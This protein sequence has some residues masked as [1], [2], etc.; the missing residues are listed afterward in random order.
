MKILAVEDSPSSRRLLQGIFLR[1]GVALPDI[2]LA[3]NATEAREIFSTWHPDVVF[4][5][6]E[7][8][9]TGAFPST[10]KPA[11][12]KSPRPMNGDELGRALLQEDPSVRLVVVTAYDPRTPAV[13]TLVAA[14]ATEVIVKPVLASRISEVLER[15][16]RTRGAG[17]A[18]R[19]DWRS[20]GLPVGA[21]PPR[22]G[23]PS[24]YP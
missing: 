1:L 10:R 2:R 3:E 12:T 4:L 20:S 9:R 13:Q 19:G 17:N 5:D 6:V 16:R 22:H 24:A 7:L 14:G 11:A 23:P 18:N 15:I 21:R 8:R